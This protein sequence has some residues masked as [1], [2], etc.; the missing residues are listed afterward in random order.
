MGLRGWGTDGLAPAGGNSATMRTRLADR[1]SGSA[2]VS[3][4]AVT[5]GVQPTEPGAAAAGGS[6]A[7]AVAASSR[8]NASWISRTGKVTATCQ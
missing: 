8:T 2:A 1:L 4:V 6:A 5:A 7:S 3:K